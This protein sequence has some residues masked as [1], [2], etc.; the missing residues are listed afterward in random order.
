[1]GGARGGFLSDQD[2]ATKV[3]LI[4]S[5]PIPRSDIRDVESSLVEGWY[6]D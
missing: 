2:F 5:L 1:M 6:K 4:T 3:K